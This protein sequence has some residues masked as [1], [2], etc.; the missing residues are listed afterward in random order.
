MSINISIYQARED[1]SKVIIEVE[2]DK[3]LNTISVPLSKFKQCTDD[4]KIINVQ[5]AV[6]CFKDVVDWFIKDQEY[7][8]FEE[9]LES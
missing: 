1:A 8:D 5:G 9:V 4:L 6:T 7:V 2:K 3:E